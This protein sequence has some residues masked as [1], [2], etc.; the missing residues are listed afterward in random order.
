MGK[1]M[2]AEQGDGRQGKILYSCE[3]KIESPESAMRGV[4]PNPP[5]IYD[6]LRHGENLYCLLFEL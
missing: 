6:M 4:S 3:Y 5:H 2:S 1:R